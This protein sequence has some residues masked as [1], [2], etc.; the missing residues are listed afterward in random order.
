MRALLI[1]PIDETV[2]LGRF[3][4]KIDLQMR[5][6]ED[7]P[8]ANKMHFYVFVRECVFETGSRRH[9][10]LGVE[11]NLSSISLLAI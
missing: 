11:S 5:N 1:I 2:S 3:D 7:V 8:S 6:N 9:R 10:G 4:F